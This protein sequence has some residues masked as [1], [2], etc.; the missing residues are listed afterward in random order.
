MTREL[1]GGRAFLLRRSGRVE[2]LSGDN[3]GS[4]LG[5]KGFRV[6]ALPSAAPEERAEL[7]HSLGGP[8]RHEADE[9]AQVLLGL[10]LVKP[11]RGDDREERGGA[12]GVVVASAE[13]PRL[14]AQR[15]SPFILPMLVS[16]P[17]CTTDGIR[18]STLRS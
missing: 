14:S 13:Q 9:A 2:R 10:D 1:R 12:L 16:R 6:E 18:G 3:N 7:D 11:C 8:Q 15:E 4:E 5:T 17:W